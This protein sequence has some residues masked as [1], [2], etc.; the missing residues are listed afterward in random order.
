[1]HTGKKSGNCKLLKNP[2]QNSM[3]QWC[4]CIC[5]SSVYVEYEKKGKNHSK[6]VVWLLSLLNNKGKKE[7]SS[8]TNPFHL[9]T[10]LESCLSQIVNSQRWFFRF[11][12]F[13]ADAILVLMCG[14]KKCSVTIWKWE[15][16]SNRKFLIIERKKKRWNICFHIFFSAFIIWF[17]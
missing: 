3:W 7:M 13:K 12:L 17:L 10:R 1:M 2:A 9:E 6:K 14:Y 8:T 5:R 16:Q 4:E 11:S 15:R